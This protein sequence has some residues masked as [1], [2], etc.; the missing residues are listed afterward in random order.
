MRGLKGE[1]FLLGMQ[2]ILERLP[3]QHQSPRVPDQEQ[4]QGRG[5]GDVEACQ[6]QL[7]GAGAFAEDGREPL[8]M[9]RELPVELREPRRQELQTVVILN[10]AVLQLTRMTSPKT[11]SSSSIGIGGSPLPDRFAEEAD[12]VEIAEQPDQSRNI[13]GMVAALQKADAGELDVDRI[14]LECPARELVADG[15]ASEAWYCANWLASPE[16]R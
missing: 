6:R 14:A 10:G 9:P 11:L 12:L 3:L 8:G 2:G 4:D 13:I 5:R 15:T 7:D 16:C 1:A